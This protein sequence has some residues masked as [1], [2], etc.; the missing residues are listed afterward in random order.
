MRISSSQVWSSALNNLMDAEQR[1]TD[2]GTQVSTQKVAT[3]LAGYG[4]GS[5]VIAAY[6]ASL[7]QTNGYI[8]VSKTVSDRLSGQDLALN[9][10]AQAASDAK[11]AV[12]N[13]VANNDSTTLMQGLQ[14]AFS[15]ALNGLNYKYN[16]SYLF[17][18]GNDD[19]P[20][21]SIS[22]MSQL[23][24]SSV[25]VASVFTNGSVK[26]A[27]TID[28]NTTVQTGMLAS[29][30]G[31]K[32]MQVFKDIQDYNDDPTTGPFATPLTD[33]QQQFLTQKSQEFSDAYDDLNNQT[34]VNGTMQ[35][36]VDSTTTS[37]QNQADSMSGL[38]SNRTDVDMSQAIT[39][40]QQAQIAVQ[41]SAEVISNLGSVSLLNYLQ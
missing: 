8:S 5:A 37:L 20:P 34:A 27:S 33:A 41:A 6:Q 36:R 10:T 32:M 1:Q 28:A 4:S 24:G 3:D 18:G 7:S 38:I 16:G 14:S 26:K 9:T 11:D 35:N 22:T 2:A 25:T 29:D 39:N 21:V 13:A 40:L 30:L 19:T 23:S 15:E 17:S 12:M 31:T